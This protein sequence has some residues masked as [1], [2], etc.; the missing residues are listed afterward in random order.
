MAAPMIRSAV[1]I[2][3][4]QTLRF[5][6]TG[7]HSTKVL[8]EATGAAI[9]T[10]RRAIVRRVLK[11]VFW[12]QFTLFLAAARPVT[13][14]ELIVVEP[15]ATLRSAAVRNATTIRTIR[16]GERLELLEDRPRHEYFHVRDIGTGE[17]GWMHRSLVRRSPDS[18]RSRFAERADASPDIRTDTEATHRHLLVGRPPEVHLRLRDGYSVAVDSRLRIPVWVQYQLKPEELRGPGDRDNSDFRADPTLPEL[19]RSNLNDYRNSGYDRGHMAPAGDM[20]RTQDVMDESFLLSNISPQV[21]NGFNRH[22]WRVLEES[23]REW[24]ANRGELTIITGP[25]FKPDSDGRVQYNVIGENQVAVPNAFFKIVVDGHPDEEHPQA[26]AFVIPNRR[27]F[28]RTIDE[29]LVSIDEIEAD[30]GLDFLQEFSDVVEDRLE[31]D[32]ATRLWNLSPRINELALAFEQ[33]Q[34]LHLVDLDADG[35]FEDPVQIA[36]I[37]RWASEHQPSHVYLLAHG[38]N[39][40]KSE[41]RASYEAFVDLM[42]RVSDEFAVRPAEY[43]PV[44]IGVRWPS[45]AWDSENSMSVLSATEDEDLTL[46]IV[47]V[48]PAEMSPGTYVD[49]VRH[50]RELLMLPESSVTPEHVQEVEVILRRYSTEPENQDDH[51]LFDEVAAPEGAAKF[52]SVRGMFRVFTFWQ[53]K[54]RAGIVGRRGGTAVLRRVMLAAPTAKFH[55]GGHSFGCKFW[56][57]SLTGPADVVPRDVDSLLL[58]QGAV[59]AWAFADQVPDTTLPGGYRSVLSRVSGPLIATYSKHDWPLQYAYPAGSMLAGQVGEL[60]SDADT[61]SPHAALGAVG[62]AGAGTASHHRTILQSGV[63][64]DLGPGIWSIQS[65]EVIDGHSGIYHAQVAWLAWAG[66]LAKHVN[67]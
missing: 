22:I 11:G 1:R 26:L 2:C 32:A 55:L 53:M 56:L 48:L 23:I 5:T 61:V 46:A 27:L 47:N 40:S 38:W 34:R 45:K 57:A 16:T 4:L 9:S 41:A 12:S 44:L 66:I 50:L 63:E 6:M 64:Y 35:R 19:V 14:D 20:K 29:F 43:R 33:N 60:S 15:E 7:S 8:A 67:P 62:A 52:D 42:G 59:S 30:S 25:L 39:T 65:D 58:L 54:K 21:G 24:V 3:N 36:G 13:A 37:E 31:A 17:T 28:E 49:D 51:S 18:A 10:T